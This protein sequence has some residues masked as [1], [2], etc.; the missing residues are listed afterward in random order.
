M[1]ADLDARGRAAAAALRAAVADVDTPQAMPT[2]RPSR[3]PQLLAAAA[4][5]VVIGLVA[6]LLA[7]RG[8]DPAELATGGPVEIPR[9]VPDQVPAGM[10]PTGRFDLPLLVGRAGGLLDMWV[11]GDAGASDPFAGGDLAVL[12]ARSTDSDGSAI[13]LGGEPLEVNGRPASIEEDGLPGTISLSIDFGDGTLVGVASTTLGADEL[14]GVAEQVGLDDGGAIMLPEDPAGLELVGHTPDASFINLGMPLPMRTGYLVGYQDD[15]DL[16]RAFLVGAVGGDEEALLVA[17]WGLGKTARRVDLRGTTGWIGTPF[18]DG[19][20]VVWEEAPGV[21]VG[22]TS[23]LT[24][25]DT[26]AAIESLRP[27]TDEEWDRLPKPTEDD[28]E[29][30]FSEVGVAIPGDARGHVTGEL[31]RG[32]WVAY[33]D[34]DGHLCMDVQQRRG[35]EGVCS[36]LDQESPAPLVVAA[37]YETAGGQVVV[38]GRVT[39]TD[40][41]EIYVSTDPGNSA[42]TFDHAPVDGGGWVFGGVFPEGGAP[43]V[44][45]IVDPQSGSELGRATVN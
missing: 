43:E 31:D 10:E 44:V 27:A 6:A 36:S 41:E 4:V 16:G 37:S 9:L 18:E 7:G 39:G 32:S 12:L 21:L 19:I 3:M 28:G 38:Y 33:V 26:L 30:E 40:V 23:G 15:D 22:V 13:E 5:I 45:T 1:P 20:S 42:A 25:T 24:E 8:D 35:G 2:A 17:R 34:V 29:T 14:I 11:Y